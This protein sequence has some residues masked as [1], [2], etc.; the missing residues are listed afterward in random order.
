MV[1]SSA[2]LFDNLQSIPLKQM[3]TVPASSA[4]PN[5]VAIARMTLPDD[6]TDEEGKAQTQT[7]IK[8]SVKDATTAEKV[9]GSAAV[10]AVDESP[11]TGDSSTWG[12]RL[13]ASRRN[14]DEESKN[15]IAAND[16]PPRIPLDEIRN[17]L[18]LLS[19]L[20]GNLS[21]IFRTKVPLDPPPD[22]P[23][24]VGSSNLTTIAEIDAGI[25]RG[26][27]R[28]TAALIDA[29]TLLNIDL[30]SAVLRKMELNRRKY[31]VELCQVS[32]PFREVVIEWLSLNHYIGRSLLTTTFAFVNNSRGRPGN[33]LSILLLPASPESRASRY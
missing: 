30:R 9:V 11:T 1:I 10:R 4:S 23:P 31:P 16:E 24:A 2:R 17:R 29:S 27:Y 32:R 13:F 14:E 18:F 3:R 5:C 6:K 12:T 33:T 19:E 8:M 22:A 7:P 25:A 20:A 21:R 28:L 26:M 15:A